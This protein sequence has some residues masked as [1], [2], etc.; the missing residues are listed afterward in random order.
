MADAVEVGFE[1]GD[2]VVVDEDGVAVDVA[3]VVDVAV[4]VARASASQRFRRKT[5]RRQCRHLEAP[6]MRMTPWRRKKRKRRKEVGG[7]RA[8]DIKATGR[9]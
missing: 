5:K 6:M 4:V 9:K 7:G 2:G 3:A 8:G 1:V